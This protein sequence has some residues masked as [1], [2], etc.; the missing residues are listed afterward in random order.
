[1]NVLAKGFILTFVLSLVDAGKFVKHQKCN[2]YFVR[3]NVTF[4]LEIF[5]DEVRRINLPIYWCAGCGGHQL[6]VRMQTGSSSCSTIVKESFSSGDDLT[7][8][9][10]QLGNCQGFTINSR[11]RIGLHTSHTNE[12]AVQGTMTIHTDS[13]QYRAN[14]PNAWRGR[15]DNS[16]TYG[17][18]I[19]Q[20]GKCSLKYVIILIYV[21]W[22]L[23]S[24]S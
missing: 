14:I 3:R 2:M 19:N 12:Y 10:R 20:S 9:R 24:K 7:W 8:S 6:S 1:M 4:H 17:I 11:T 13:N 15:H 18:T 16:K 21:M 23:C 5:S 22:W